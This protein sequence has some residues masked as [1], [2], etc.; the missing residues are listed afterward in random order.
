MVEI[1]DRDYSILKVSL[2]YKI[3]IFPYAVTCF[4]SF[5]SSELHSKETWVCLLGS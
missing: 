2:P 3:P 4:L 1:C 5:C